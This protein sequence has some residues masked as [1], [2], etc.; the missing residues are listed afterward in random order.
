VGWPAPNAPS[1]WDRYRPPN[2]ILGYACIDVQDWREGARAWLRIS[3]DLPRQDYRLV[4]TNSS[5]CAATE[6]RHHD[7]ISQR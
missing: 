3:N 4:Q 5:F 6:K 7:V 2:L 1:R